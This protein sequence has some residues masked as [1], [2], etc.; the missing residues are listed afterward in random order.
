MRKRI[1]KQTGYYRLSEEMK[2]IL[3]LLSNNGMM[4]SLYL[5]SSIAHILDSCNNDRIRHLN[6][7]VRVLSRKHRISFRR[8]LIKLQMMNLI[9]CEGKFFQEYISYLLGFVP[10][11]VICLKKRYILSVDY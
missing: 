9:F 6:D 5:S 7:D 4:D 2:E 3:R 10:A 1:R 11:D 8:S